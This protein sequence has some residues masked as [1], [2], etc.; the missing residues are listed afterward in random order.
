MHGLLLVCRRRMRLMGI[1]FELVTRERFY[2]LA[3]G[4]SARF[5]RKASVHPEVIVAIGRGGP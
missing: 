5:P 2:Q 4:L 3:Q 1:R